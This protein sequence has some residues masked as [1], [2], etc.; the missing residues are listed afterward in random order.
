MQARH[1]YL[2]TLCRRTFRLARA[3][4]PFYLALLVYTISAL[5]L[6]DALGAR[7]Q[8]TY[9]IYLRRWAV[10][11]LFMMPVVA[12]AVD[13]FLVIHRF[14]HRRK[15][16][17]RYAFSPE[18]FARLFSGL[19]LLMA[20][21]LFQGSFTSI[22]NVL[23]VIQEGFPYDRIQADID[24][25]LHF[26]ADP[27]RWLFAVG[28][29][30]PVRTVVEWNYNFLWF[31]ISFGALFF[32]V[33]SPR[34]A[35]VRSRYLTAFMLNWLVVGNVLAGLFLSAGPA[36]YG[37]VTGDEARFAA[38]LAFLAGSADSP[39]S[40]AAYQAYLWS[41]HESGNPGFGS[42]ISAFPSMHVA[43]AAM[44]AFFLAE[45]SRRWG[46]AALVYLA[47]ITA[48]SVYLGWHYAI[49]GYVAIIVVAAIHYA[50]KRVMPLRFAVT[51]RAGGL[52]AEAGSQTV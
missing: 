5:L 25:W 18:R 31:V 16:A 39:H 38:Q 6:L 17:A 20:M 30:A 12:L 13:A 35:A 37:M 51:P 1:G 32:V 23:P 28:E 10:L 4:A 11:F 26:G 2:T 45:Y 15:L 22:K 47:F 50:L 46:M 21:V 48:S 36:F 3:D 52:P 44:N 34:A 49:D 43:L 27:W 7:E 41:L 42:G 24:R 33:T 29:S 19:A 8:T 40:A 9:A 14:N